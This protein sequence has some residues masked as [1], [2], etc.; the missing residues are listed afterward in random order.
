[1]TCL[2][3]G[4]ELTDTQIKFC[5]KSCA[6][7][8]NNKKRIKTTKGKTKIHKCIKCGKEFTGSIHLN[9]KLAKCD[10][11]SKK[12]VTKSWI[13]D[14][15]KANIQ[16]WMDEHL[17]VQKIAELL[18]VGLH[19]TTRYINSIDPSYRKTSK[20]VSLSAQQL[21]MLHEMVSQN[22]PIATIAR[23]FT[24]SYWT[25]LKILKIYYPDYKCTT[26][27]KGN[28]KIP[29]MELLRSN[30]AVS[31]AKIRKKLIE[32]GYK[33]AKCECCG[34]SEWMGKP[35]VLEL[36]HKDFNHWNTNIDNF[37][38]LCPNCHA[39]IHKNNIH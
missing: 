10:N 37:Q 6:A 7:T 22:L 14:H 31:N 4:K 39:Y 30:S 5:S 23:Q 27:F 38:I 2:Q 3:C 8:Y 20:R 1:M 29:L 35:I 15:N 12:T 36:H 9:P 33:E 18:G 25:M 13:F 21:N 17:S 32:E 19:T 28:K 16:K 26:N 11:C 34:L 24:V